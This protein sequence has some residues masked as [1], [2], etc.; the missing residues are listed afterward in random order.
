M[1]TLAGFGKGLVILLLPFFLIMTSI[2]ILLIPYLY[3]E[4]EYHTPN[5]PPDVYGFTLQDR[6]Q[7]SKVSFDYLL[8]DQPLSWLANQKLPD[9]S[10]LYVDRE[11]SHMLDVKNLIQL[12][13]T[14]WWI[15]LTAILGIGLLLWRAGR[16][17]D[18]W[19]A[20]SSGGWLTI[21]LIAAVLILVVISFN[22][23]FT[24][25]HRLFFSG[26]SWL[27]LFS[28]TLIRLFPMKFWQDAFLW[29][30]GFTLVFA[31]LFGYFGRRAAH[32]S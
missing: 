24:D 21:G 32:R 19:Q 7:W 1:K 15:F 14:V 12:M 10:P 11:L 8:N 27:F 22:S 4:Y 20:L 23:L 28:D 3:V 16:I 2:R 17:K 31:F 26:D 5:F 30:G 29:M 9:G 13:F 25:F 18:Y 6:L